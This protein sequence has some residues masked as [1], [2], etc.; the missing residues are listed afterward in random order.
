MIH[1][2]NDYILENDKLQLRPLLSA[3]FDELLEFAMNEPDVWNILLNSD[4]GITS[5]QAK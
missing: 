2:E 3:D 1:F 5:L 4:P